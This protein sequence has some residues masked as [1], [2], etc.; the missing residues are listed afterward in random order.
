[1]DFEIKLP[2]LARHEYTIDYATGNFTL[3]V[4]DYAQ[5]DI[6]K[7]FTIQREYNSRTGIWKFN[8][9]GRPQKLTLQSL[10]EI[11]FIYEGKNLISFKDDIG[12]TT[13]YEYEENLLTGVI[14]PDGTKIKYS[15]NYEKQLTVCIERDKKIFQNEYDGFGRLIKFSDDNGTRNFF[16]DYKNRQTI[17]SGRD[18]IIYQWNRRKLVEKII[19]AD[20][21]SEIFQYDA[22]NRLNYKRTC[23]GKEYFWRYLNDRLSREIL[24]GGKIVAF[25]YDSVGN[26]IKQM[27][28]DGRE[29]VFSY[30]TKNLLIKKKTKLNIKD[31]RV[32]TWERDI[33]GRVLK[34]EV[35]GQVTS[36]AYD[37][38]APVPSMIK[39]PCGYKFTCIYDKVYR[40]LTLRTEVGEFSFS[41]TTMNKIVTAKKNIFMPIELPEKFSEA[42][43][44]K[45]FD[46]G[47]RLIETRIKI[48]DKF[49]LIRWKYDL[50]DNCI[51]RR[52]WRDLQTK[53]SATGRVKVIKY[54]YDAQNRLIRKTE[55]KNVTKYYYDCLNCLTRER[56]TKVE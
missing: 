28:S 54:E 37:D 36:Y 39:T 5:Q 51:E 2:E 43:D 23:D 49:K 30:S 24:P 16:R 10:R 11:F 31:W 26:L 3:K 13:R 52:E 40:L 20:E 22:D 38:E 27:D 18:N 1:M 34:Y 53:E 29:E 12:R 56:T 42:A 4:T 32:E 21:S 6:L 41:H 7:V 14:Y 33:A 46:I 35:N 15:Y 8:I 45:I 47:G 44:I 25:E 19:Y 55:G 48:E 9:D 17:E 50:N